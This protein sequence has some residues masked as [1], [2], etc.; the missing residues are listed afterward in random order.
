MSHPHE[1]SL[2][3]ALLQGV[4]SRDDCGCSTFLAGTILVPSIPLIHLHL[5]S[6][7]F[8]LLRHSRNSIFHYSWL[9]V[10]SVGFSVVGSRLHQVAMRCRHLHPLVFTWIVRKP[11]N[12]L[13]ALSVFAFWSWGEQM[14]KY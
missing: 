2:A 8:C 3:Y 11:N 1:R 13:P 6:Y 5:E 7:A 4:E 10:I 12:M 9:L 14:Q